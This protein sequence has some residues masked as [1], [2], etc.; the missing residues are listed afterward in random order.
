MVDLSFD[1]EKIKASLAKV[2]QVM[3]WEVQQAWKV[4]GKMNFKLEKYKLQDE[5][6][7]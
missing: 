4:P 2:P 3:A 6:L 7:L 1:E 5:K